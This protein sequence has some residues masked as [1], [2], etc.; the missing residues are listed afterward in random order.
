MRKAINLPGFGRCA[1]ESGNGRH[2]HLVHQ[3]M[4]QSVKCN[5]CSHIS[6][7]LYQIMP[8]SLVCIVSKPRDLSTEQVIHQ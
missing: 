6:N 1:A 8:I 5:Q 3:C 4:H 2:I 7:V